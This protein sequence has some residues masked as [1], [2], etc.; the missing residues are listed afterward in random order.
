MII[1][2]FLGFQYSPSPL[3][4]TNAGFEPGPP[5]RVVNGWTV[6]D[7]INKSKMWLKQRNQQMMSRK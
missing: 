3:P 4:N 7:Q 2:L 1:H 6:D 5:T